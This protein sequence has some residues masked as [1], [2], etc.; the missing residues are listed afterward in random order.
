MGKFKK[1]LETFL[2]QGEELARQ[3][4]DSM[5]LRFILQCQSDL[6]LVSEDKAKAIACLEELRDS[7]DRIRMNYW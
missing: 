3:H 6:H 2:Q 4:P 7:V 1:Q 5:G